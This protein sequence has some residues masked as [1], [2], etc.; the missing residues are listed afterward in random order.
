MISQACRLLAYL[1]QIDDAG[2]PLLHMAQ[3]SSSERYGHEEKKAT[4]Q[5]IHTLNFPFLHM[6]E[7]F[8]AVFTM[9]PPAGVGRLRRWR[10]RLFHGRTE[11][12]TS[13]RRSL[14]RHDPCPES[15]EVCQI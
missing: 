15:A 12:K 4:P 11:R 3:S 5:T 9:R 10:R 13:P 1:S 8:S 7:G 14:S 6:A 2:S